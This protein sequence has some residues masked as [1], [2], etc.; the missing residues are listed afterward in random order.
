LSADSVSKIDVAGTQVPRYDHFSRRVPGENECGLGDVP[1]FCD[2]WQTPPALP[3]LGSAALFPTVVDGL[4]TAL[5]V[6]WG[7][8]G[9][10]SPCERAEGIA[11]RILDDDVLLSRIAAE[12]QRLRSPI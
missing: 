6:G 12:F 8:H 1:V 2:G 7:N 9:P 4:A 3:M 5:G 11:R 10:A